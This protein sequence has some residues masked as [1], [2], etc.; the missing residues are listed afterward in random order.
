MHARRASSAHGNV[1]RGE[2][3]LM[4]LWL[5]F[6]LGLIGPAMIVYGKRDDNSLAMI[7]GAVLLVASLF[8][9]F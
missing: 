8:I 2:E 6:I 1:P 3:T 7:I 5:S 4:K 9:M